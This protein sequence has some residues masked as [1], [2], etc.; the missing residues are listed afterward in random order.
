MKTYA[1]ILAGGRGE[2]FWP[3]SRR[4]FPKQFLRLFGRESLIQMTAR[5][6]EPICPR[7]NQRFVVDSNL[8]PVL[9][10]QLR[11]APRSFVF[12]PSGRNTAPAIALAAAYV[13]REEPD[14]TLVVLPADHRIEDVRRFQDAVRFA[15]G[16]AQQGYLV[17]FGIPP[18]R[19]DTNYGYIEIGEPLGS[20]RGRQ[21][22]AVRRFREKPDLRQAKGFLRRGGFWWNSGMFVWRTDA[23]LHAVE[24][25]MPDF[26]RDL[27]KFQRRIGT[28][29]ERE[30]A[31]RLYRRVK[32]ESVDYAIME[33]ARNVAVVRA[34]FD[35]D[36]VG[37]WSAL[38]R[39]FACD[40]SGNVTIGKLA[41]LDAKRCLCSSDDGTIALLGTED[42]IVVRSK[43]AVLVAR[44][45]RAGEIKRLLALMAESPSLKRYL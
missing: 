41:A 11:L 31:E 26:H 36:D 10:R 23:F 7:P 17:T 22:F 9:R 33:K 27:A 20:R 16:L 12:E 25:F 34:G 19:P 4:S 29:G 6:I 18:D 13:A 35:W 24:L 2:R 14:S 32:P 38:E 30:A 45:D 3:A 28:A 43:D 40:P 44:K 39:H 15:V 21:A 1:V 8:G 42:L 37:S 5:R